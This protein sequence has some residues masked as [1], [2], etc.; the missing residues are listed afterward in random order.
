MKTRSCGRAAAVRRLLTAGAS[1]VALSTACAGGALAQDVDVEELPTVEP[2]SSDDSREDVIIVTGS[3]IRRRV[4]ETVG[5]TE[6]GELEFQQRGFIN[7]IEALEELPFVAIGVNNTG[8]STQFGDNNAFVNLLNFGTARTLTLIDGRR[9]V[10][11]N[12]GTVFVPGNETGA[13]VDL[14]IINP[15]LIKRTEV[16]TIGSGPIYGSD[17][18]AGVVNVILDRDLEGLKFSA[19]GG[20]TDEGDGE[21]GRV[22]AAWGKELFGGRGHLVLAGEYLNSN[23]IYGN[24]DRPFTNSI[25]VINN[26]LS[27][28]GTD[29]IPDQIFQA[30]QQNPQIPLGGRMDLRQTNATSTA[31]IF[32]PNR[33]GNSANDPAFN[34]FVA[35]HGGVTPFDFA[36][37]N[38]GLNGLNPLAFIG[39]FGLNSGFPTVPVAPGSPEALVLL[40]QKV[41][42]LKGLRLT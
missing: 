10:S 42:G 41:T 1:A 32:F 7:A 27:F 23:A 33:L 28:T 22:S 20:I 16:K 18:V 29:Q 13:Q 17:A 35:A 5:V 31:N 6:I 21:F 11:S 26:P 2:V 39:T 12:Q 24:S 30:N 40:S 37:Q 4:D 14:T 15:S 25:D 38:P 19:Q 8:N 9:M 3:R 34:A 36:L